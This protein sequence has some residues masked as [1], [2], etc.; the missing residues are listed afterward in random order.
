[1][2]YRRAI[3]V[4]CVGILN[5]EA[6]VAAMQPA[7]WLS[8]QDKRTILVAASA[9]TATWGLISLAQKLYTRIHSERPQKKSN[10]QEMLIPNM[11]EKINKLE[12]RIEKLQ[13]KA[14]TLDASAA[15]F[16]LFQ[17][18]GLLDKEGN[19]LNDPENKIESQA[20]AVKKLRLITSIPGQVDRLTKSIQ[21]LKQE[22][23]EL[24]EAIKKQ[25]EQ[26]TVL[27]ASRSETIPGTTVATDTKK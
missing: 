14:L 21:E 25:A 5:L 22:N 8:T 17:L 1:M 23:K 3:I 4:L 7:S 12:T 20:Y 10:E 11:Q 18:H 19:F 13:D 16:G 2:N 6:P 26:L 9:A 15:V 24:K 27:T